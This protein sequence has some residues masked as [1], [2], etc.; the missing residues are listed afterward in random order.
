MQIP[1]KLLSPSAVIPARAKEH[2]A[3]YDLFNAEPEAVVLQQNERRLFPTGVAMAIPAGY[4]GRIADRSGLAK[5]EG[6]HVLG[7]V[8]DCGYGGN[9]GVILINLGWL[10]VRIEPGQRIAQIIIERCETA[11]FQVVDEL[12][13]SERGAGGFGSTG[14]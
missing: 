3:G 1:I 10:P 13:T 9:I 8:V 2:D 7:G 5:K 11:E 14:S 12:P 6:L 4:Y